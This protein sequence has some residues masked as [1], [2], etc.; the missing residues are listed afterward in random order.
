MYCY[1]NLHMNYILIQA[2]IKKR[3]DEE[4]ISSSDKAEQKEAQQRFPQLMALRSKATYLEILSPES[5]K[6]SAAQVLLAHYGL[7]P[8]Q[9]AAFGDSDVDAD[10]LQYCGFGV[11]MGNAP[12]SVKEAAD[13]VTAS[14]DE[15][16]VFIALNSLRLK[17]PGDGKSPRKR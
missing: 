4:Q 13:Y 2:T 12:R 7:E 14:N 1:M 17:A 6:G 5:T 10:M 9:A 11:A 16:G 8:E 15:E 3:A